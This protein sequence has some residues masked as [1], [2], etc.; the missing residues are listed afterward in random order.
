M[1]RHSGELP[2]Q[3][4]LEYYTDHNCRKLKGKIDLDQCEQVIQYNE[5]NQQCSP[6]H[7]YT[8]PIFHL[9]MNFSGEVFGGCASQLFTA[10]F[11]S[12]YSLKCSIF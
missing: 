4:F 9:G 3:Y 11:T 2:G 5:I 12:L 10:C 1:L 8:S 6:H 7:F